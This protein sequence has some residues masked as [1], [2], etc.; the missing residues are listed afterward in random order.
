M[1]DFNNLLNEFLSGMPDLG[2][3]FMRG[4]QYALGAFVL[5]GI[6]YFLRRYL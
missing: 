2:A 4:A 3:A 5:V 1:P 6:I